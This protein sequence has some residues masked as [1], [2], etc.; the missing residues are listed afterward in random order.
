M[1]K[2]TAGTRKFFQIRYL[3]PSCAGPFPPFSENNFLGLSLSEI[4]LFYVMTFYSRPFTVA[5]GGGSFTVSF[6]K[7]DNAFMKFRFEGEERPMQIYS[8]L[9]I[10][11]PFYDP[12]CFLGSESRSGIRT[13]EES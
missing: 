8:G 12:Q 5:S 1:Q 2:K 6:P 13:E 9:C 7:R 4:D 10:L 11:L 3:N